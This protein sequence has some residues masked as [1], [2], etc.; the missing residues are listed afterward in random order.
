MRA[1][2][3]MC[4]CACA[5]VC[6]G[7]GV[8]VGEHIYVFIKIFTKS[9]GYIPTSPITPNQRNT[10]PSKFLSAFPSPAEAVTAEAFQSLSATLLLQPDVGG[11]GTP[12]GESQK[13]Y[14]YDS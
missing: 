2:V 4:E 6:L 9:Q 13:Y 3:R 5:F 12:A 10:E 11:A 7:V 14:L 1:R 8:S